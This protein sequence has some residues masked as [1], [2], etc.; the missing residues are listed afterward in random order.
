MF[1]YYVLNLEEQGKID[2]DRPLVTYADQTI[3]LPSD[4]PAF[5]KVTARHVLMHASGLP[6]WGDAPLALR[7]TPG[8]SF[9]YS[10]KP[11]FR[12]SWN[13]SWAPGSMFCYRRICSI[14]W[15]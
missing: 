5:Q 14:L 9:S 15:E 1:A 10:G 12:R 2:L 13:T 4:D 11:S 7:C 8:T 3:L 6:N